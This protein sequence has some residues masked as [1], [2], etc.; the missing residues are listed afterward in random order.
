MN[1]YLARLL[2]EKSE[3]PLPEAPSK[4][5]K[6]LSGG[7]E[8]VFEGFEG[9]Q[10]SRVSENSSPDVPRL[11]TA[12]EVILDRFPGAEIV[13]LCCYD[14]RDHSQLEPLNTAGHLAST[15]AQCRDQD[16][17]AARW[18]DKRWNAVVWLH[19]ECRR[20]WLARDKFPIMSAV[21]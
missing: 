20:H 5:S 7:D 9:D 8:M 1:R 17:R 3:T 15:C 6:I 2:A 13:S 19:T 16:G 4:P 12:L 11:R 18:L 14:L 10:G 21:K